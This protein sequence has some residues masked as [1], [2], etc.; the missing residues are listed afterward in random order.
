MEGT[1]LR[2][3]ANIRWIAVTLTLFG[4]AACGGG[5]GGGGIAAPSALSYPTPPSF[6]VGSAIATLTPTVSGSVT[7]FTV[8]PALPAGLT[9]STTT[10]VISGTPSAITAGANYV[11]TATNSAGSTDA[12]LSIVVNDVPPSSI[13]YATAKI[14]F[15]TGLPGNALTPKSGGGAIVAWSIAPALPSGLTLSATT[16]SIS[17]TPTADS[18]ATAYVVTATNSGGHST[19]TLTIQV[20][21][22]LLLDL[23]HVTE[24]A[25]LQLSGNR[26]LSEDTSS[27]WNLRDYAAGTLLASG[28]GSCVLT[29]GCGNAGIYT[30]QVGL[31]GQT[32]VIET[33]NGLEIRSA[34]DGSLLATIPGAVSWWTLASDGSYVSVGTTAGLKAYSTSGV[35]L[36]SETGDFSNAKVFAAPGQIQVALGPA[37]TSVIQTILVPNGT[38]SLS[39]PYQGTFN[40][41][42]LDGGRFLTNTGSTVWTYSSNGVQQ[43]ITALTTSVQGLTG[44]GNWFWTTDVTLNIYAVGPSNVPAASYSFANGLAD[45]YSVIG[46]GTSIAVLPYQNA[47]AAIVD[48]SG[49]APALVNYALP[50]SYPHG[51][52]ALSASTWLVGDSHGATV[53]GSSLSGTPRFLTL[54][55]ATSIA[56]A[57]GLVAIAT[58]SGNVLVMNPQTM[59]LQVSIPFTASK[60]QISTDGTVLAAMG[61][62]TAGECATDC[63]AMTYSLP[64]GTAIFQ[65]SYAGQSPTLSD[66]SLSASGTVIAQV[67][68]TSRQATAVTGGSVIWSDSLGNLGNPPPVQLS[69]DGTLIAA[70]NGNPAEYEMVGPTAVNIYKNG[71]L[72]TAVSSWSPGWID[73]NSLLVNAYQPLSN[74]D[75]YMYLGSSIYDST[76]KLLASPPLPELRSMQPVNAQSVYSAPYNSIFSLSTGSALWT[77]A[78]TNSTQQP[79]GTGAVTS[80]YVVFP[81]GTKI[82]AEPQ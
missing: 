32:V 20:A 61:V 47:T 8:A 75:G 31:A 59:T 23:G 41:W 21:S 77:S 34:T 48:L 39:P 70:D 19:A 50:I 12:T 80:S 25:T 49:A 82:L 17:G 42:F 44:Q 33:S 64:G 29:P 6:T 16:G 58:D 3:R 71:G 63:M 51:F 73:N 26:L 15:A 22:S 52:A 76:G 79:Y 78:N 65:W 27:H 38:S 74:E 11:V 55:R 5:H 56:G 1:A 62:S 46:S 36:V 28:D 57:A 68:A 40:S 66:I 45:D 60:V 69:P 81:S 9:L 54:G 14:A 18:P 35:A 30:A 67:L 24:I 10:G 4:L 2:C 7:G 53:D 13:N 72:V 37:G 43:A